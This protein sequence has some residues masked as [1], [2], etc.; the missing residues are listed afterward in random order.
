MLETQHLVLEPFT[1]EQ[2]I[3]LIEAPETFNEF[4]RF[5]AAEGLREFFTSGDVDPA[6]L[7]SLKSLDASSPWG[8]GFAVIDTESRQIIGSGGFKGSPDADGTVEI[9]YGIV[10]SFEGRGYATEGA[11]ALTEYCFANGVLCVRAHTLPVTNA[12]NRILA[13]CGFEFAGEMIDPNDGPVWRWE[14]PS[15]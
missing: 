6:W 13:K 15:K 2:L 4:S 12:S 8:L 3:A 14:R 1:S 5:P 9:A 11:R 10:P 7:T